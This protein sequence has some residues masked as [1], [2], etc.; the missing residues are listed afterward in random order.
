MKMLS[1]SEQMVDDKVKHIIDTKAEVL[2]GSDLGCLMNIGGR[3]DRL[4]VNVEVM[5][6]AE[7][8]N[9]QQETGETVGN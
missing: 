5:H 3:L 9:H 8:L 6:I 1:I 2:V 4:G 7:V